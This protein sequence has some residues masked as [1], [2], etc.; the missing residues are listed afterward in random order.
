MHSRRFAPRPTRR[1]VLA[2][3]LVAGTGLLFRDRFLLT[4]A[5]P[6]AATEPIRTPNPRGVCS[7]LEEELGYTDAATPGGTFIDSN[8]NDIQTDS[9]VASRRQVLIVGRWAYV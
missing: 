8:V 4:D 6:P 9:S 3:A 5:T 1:N 7:R 2:G